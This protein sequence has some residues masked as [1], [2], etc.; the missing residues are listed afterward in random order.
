MASIL[1]D[2]PL[3]LEAPDPEEVKMWSDKLHLLLR[4]IVR[5][6]RLIEAQA[7]VAVWSVGPFFGPDAIVV[8]QAVPLFIVPAAADGFELTDLKVSFQAGTLTGATEIEVHLLSSAGDTLLGTSIL[9]AVAVPLDI[10]TVVLSSPIPIV[11]GDRVYWD[12]VTAGG[13][14]AVTAVVTGRQAT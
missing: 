10:Y 12:C 9:S 5:L 8:G 3:L 4:E 1:D 11:A 14:E 13:H 6:L 2:I 7:G